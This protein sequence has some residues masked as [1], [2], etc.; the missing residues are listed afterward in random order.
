MV[1]NCSKP[2]SGVVLVRMYW[3]TCGLVSAELSLLC[4]RIALL[5][6]VI[7][8]TSSDTQNNLTASSCG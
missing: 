8:D 2:K 3:V 7:S 5:K 4:D 6:M 1:R